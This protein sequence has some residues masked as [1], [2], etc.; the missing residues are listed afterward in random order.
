VVVDERA[1]LAVE[2]EDDVAAVEDVADHAGG[3]E[4]VAAAENSVP[5]PVAQVRLRVGVGVLGL[6]PIL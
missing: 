1:V 6:G 3:E 2:E 5:D 4:V